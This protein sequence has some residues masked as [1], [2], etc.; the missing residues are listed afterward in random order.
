MEIQGAYLMGTNYKKE[1]KINRIKKDKI[2]FDIIEGEKQ[3]KFFEV[4]E[5]DEDK[6]SKSNN[7]QGKK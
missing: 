2:P 5:K 1:I 3:Y 7:K 4:K 6:R